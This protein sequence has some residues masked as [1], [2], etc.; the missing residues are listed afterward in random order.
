MVGKHHLERLLCQ[1]TVSDIGNEHVRP[2]VEV[3]SIP[4]SF[5]VYHG[6]YGLPI[7][8]DVKPRPCKHRLATHVAREG[9]CPVVFEGTLADIAVQDFEDASAVRGERSLAGAAVVTGGCLLGCGC[10]C[11]C[12]DFG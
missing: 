8:Y 2:G 5:D 1:A 4:S 6:A 7:V 12:P 3:S 10:A 11:G 9:E